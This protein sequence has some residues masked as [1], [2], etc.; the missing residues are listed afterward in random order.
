MSQVCW[1]WLKTQLHQYTRTLYSRMFFVFVLRRWYDQYENKYWKAPTVITTA[2][3]EH[4]LWFIARFLKTSHHTKFSRLVSI[5]S[6]AL[7]RM[8]SEQARSDSSHCWNLYHLSPLRFG[9]LSSRIDSTG[10][11]STAWQFSAACDLFSCVTLTGVW[12]TRI[13]ISNRRL[14]VWSKQ[15][16]VKSGCDQVFSPDIEKRCFMI[17][18]WRQRK[19]DSL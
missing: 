9:L 12:I 18:R 5:L 13:R 2:A 14:T 16:R 11:W 3:P 8:P 15:K 10:K 4:C 1:S 19:H 6:K 7:S 17:T